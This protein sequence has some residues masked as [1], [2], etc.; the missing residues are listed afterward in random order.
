MK[1]KKRKADQQEGNEQ[2]RKK[3][4]T[5]QKQEMH[6][7]ARR[8]NLLKMLDDLDLLYSDLNRIILEYEAWSFEKK[9][10]I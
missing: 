4:E 9:I 10:F 6:G 2:K 1:S 3:E 7:E 5:K 8:K